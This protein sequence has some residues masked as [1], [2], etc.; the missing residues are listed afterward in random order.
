MYIYLDKKGVVKEIIND[1]ALRQASSN[2]NSVYI[3]YDGYK[4]DGVTSVL[5]T[6][7]LPNGTITPEAEVA[8]E[9]Q[10]SEI[11][12][13][14]ERDLKFFEYYT[15]YPFYVFEIAD[16]ALSQSG[17]VR[18][19]LRMVCD[20]NTAIK[21]QGLICF[22]VE[23]EAVQPDYDMSLSQYNYL[24]KQ[25]KELNLAEFVKKQDDNTFTGNNTFAGS[26][27]F[28]K[29]VK[30]ATPT[31]DTSATTKKYVDDRDSSVLSTAKADTEAK[32]TKA[33]NDAKDYT[34]NKIGAQDFSNFAKKSEANTFAGSNQF[35]KEVKVATPT[36]DTSATTKKYVDD[37]DSSVLST[38]KA[39]TEAKTTKALNDAKDYTDNKIG[40]QDFSNFAK[41]SEANTF[42]KKQILSEGAILGKPLEVDSPY[43]DPLAQPIGNYYADGVRVNRNGTYVDLQYP[44]K[45]GTFALTSDTKEVK[46]YVDANFANVEKATTF[47]ENVTFSKNV[48]VNGTFTKVNAETISTK[49]YT[50]ALA[51][52]NTASIASYVGFYATKYNGK[53][54]GGIFFDN[55]GTAYVGDAT[56]NDKGQ[57]TDG[58]K[59]LPLMAR[60]EADKI[61][62]KALLFW[63]LDAQ[64]AEQLKDSAGVVYTP[65]YFDNFAKKSQDNAFDG[66]NTFSK[67][68]VANGGINTK[69]IKGKDL[70]IQSTEGNITLSVPGGYSL[71][72]SNWF[73][74][75][76]FYTPHDHLSLGYDG[77]KIK[78]RGTNETLYNLDDF[79]TNTSL[80]TTL[81]DY[82][83]SSAF[84]TSLG[85]YYTKSEVDAKIA[86]VSGGGVTQSGDNT[87][88][89]T[90]TFTKGI[91][92]KEDTSSTTDTTTYNGN[93]ISR[94]RLS[95]A[96]GTSA[97]YNYALP[98]KSGTLA[99]LENLVPS[100]GT[101]VFRSDNISP[102]TIYPNTTW[103]KI[104]GR[105]IMGASDAYP[106]GST[107][108]EATH[109]LTI[110]EMPSHGHIENIAIQNY[111]VMLRMG[112]HRD[113]LT[114][115]YRMYEIKEGFFSSGF[116]TLDG[117]T[118]S[119]TKTN[120][121][122]RGF[123][124]N[125]LQPYEACN[126]YKRIA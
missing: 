91:V 48:T 93:H 70:I 120:A 1:E 41:K 79:V 124:H 65:S 66:A 31:L 44:L 83:T 34:D 99:L 108:G 97:S 84:N 20:D 86:D 63:N 3:Y 26:N 49:E 112:G 30:V 22:T 77:V 69:T 76:T 74:A 110:D 59:L 16:L 15:E 28:T 7:E 17:T 117:Y 111:G 109:T 61:T 122:G 100:I 38:A 56:I 46:D 57:V 92:A 85:N 90:N 113:E 125:N 5:A 54:D 102:S 67:E 82:V 24:V 107:G 58:S 116:Q 8:T 12:Y 80:T 40:A 37:R 21:S 118:S 87:F 81:G 119:A 23:A 25:W 14:A 123:E 101:I 50:I 73:S 33:L 11:P 55:T 126:V 78:L 60:D 104:E 75:D 62:D 52:G 18:L 96:G 4:E 9:T 64:K 27:Q 115:G 53:E 43:F 29:E 94:V 45:K 88:T 72:T 51:K 98:D 106:L 121:E 68:I 95:K 42:I 2:A 105:V 32:T 10:T 47:K 39:D 89:G 114:S 13:N 71:V 36:L 35:T 103:E 19:T 6:Y